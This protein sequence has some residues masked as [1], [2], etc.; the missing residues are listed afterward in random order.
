MYGGC[1]VYF[2]YEAEFFEA[3]MLIQA[4]RKDRGSAQCMLLAVDGTN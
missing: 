2:N 3:P 1:Q 4:S